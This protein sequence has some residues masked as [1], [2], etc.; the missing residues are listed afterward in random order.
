MHEIDL[1]WK[2]FESFV[3]QLQICLKT[4]FFKLQFNLLLFDSKVT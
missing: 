4:R 2:T 3:K 1:S